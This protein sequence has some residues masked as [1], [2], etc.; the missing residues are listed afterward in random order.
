MHIAYYCVEC[1]F[2]APRAYDLMLHQ[3]SEHKHTCD[4]SEYTAITSKLPS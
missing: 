1:E 2:L 4:L 3:D